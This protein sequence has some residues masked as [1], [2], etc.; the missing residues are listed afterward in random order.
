VTTALHRLIDGAMPLEQWVATVRATVPA[1]SEPA[2]RS[3]LGRL[4]AR[5]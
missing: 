2:A 3:W 5:R 4:R 1:R